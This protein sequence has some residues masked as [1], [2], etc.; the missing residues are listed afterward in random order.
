MTKWL[1]CLEVW[2][3]F[4]TKFINFIHMSVR[5]IIESWLVSPHKV[6]AIN[7]EWESRN[8]VKKHVTLL[9][10]AKRK[11]SKN[12]TK[13]FKIWSNWFN[14][15]SIKH[16]TIVSKDFSE[17]LSVTSIHLEESDIFLQNTSINSLS[18]FESES[19][20]KSSK[21]VE[22]KSNENKETDSNENNI[23]AKPVHV[24]WNFSFIINS[25]YCV[26]LSSQEKLFRH[27]IAK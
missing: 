11:S 3:H 2:N 4:I 17:R 9:I 6:W 13:G 8:T 26:F 22:S 16:L 1:S 25:P 27:H 7:E 20:C 21:T 23:K 18:H 14:T 5:A 12:C 19:H 10:N 15:C 24:F